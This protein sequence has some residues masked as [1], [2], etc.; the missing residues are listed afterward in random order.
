MFNKPQID[1]YYKKE[2]ITRIYHGKNLTVS[3]EV[4]V[5]HQTEE[6]VAKYIFLS[7]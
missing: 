3:K 6:E 7:Q 2:G 5:I 1:E 4:I